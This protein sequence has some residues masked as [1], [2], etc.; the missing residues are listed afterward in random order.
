[1]KKFCFK[2]FGYSF[3]SVFNKIYYIYC[4]HADQTELYY[5]PV[6]VLVLTYVLMCVEARGLLQ[7]SSSITFQLLF[8]FKLTYFMC[9]S[10]LPSCMHGHCMYA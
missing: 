3:S 5:F 2:L 6:C 9:M 1:M 7:V 10:V 8:F 4:F